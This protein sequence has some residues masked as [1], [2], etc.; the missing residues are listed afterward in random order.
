[1]AFWEFM[2]RIFTLDISWIAD[3]IMSNLLWVFMIIAAIYILQ[4]GKKVLLGSITA[5]AVIFISI[6]L[7]PFFN[8]AIYTAMGL[9]VLFLLRLTLIITTENT[10]KLSGFLKLA[11]FLSWYVTLYVY[12]IYL[13]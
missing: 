6:D 7:D 2:V 3:A 4:G 11:W 9:I 8:L 13:V 12:N 5:V 1:M 10:P